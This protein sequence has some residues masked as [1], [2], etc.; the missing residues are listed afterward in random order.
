MP[1]VNQA[2]HSVAKVAGPRKAPCKQDVSFDNCQCVAMPLSIVNALL[3]KI[4]PVM[5]YEREGNLYLAQLR[6]SSFT[7]QGAHA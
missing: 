4:K 5:I 1:G 6:M 7:R 3:G 2:L